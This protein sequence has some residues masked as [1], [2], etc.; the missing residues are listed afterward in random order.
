MSSRLAGP[1]RVRGA[2][3]SVSRLLNSAPRGM[4][5]LPMNVHGRDARAT[6]LP[7]RAKSH[8]TK[9]VAAA[10]GCVNLCGRIGKSP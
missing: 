10:T 2:F 8:G 5:I 4:G 9:P 7:L 6:A 1:G 3:L